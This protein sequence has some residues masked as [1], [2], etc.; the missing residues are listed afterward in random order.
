MLYAFLKLKRTS[1]LYALSA[2]R[3]IPDEL[4]F[5]ARKRTMESTQP[6]QAQ[7]TRVGYLL[8]RAAD[9]YPSLARFSQSIAP[10]EVIQISKFLF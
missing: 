1:D 7:S 8:R 9:T 2:R 6:S 4:V 5:S 10:F 3:C